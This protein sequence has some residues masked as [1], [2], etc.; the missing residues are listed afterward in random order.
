MFKN[1]LK[2]AV[3][4]TALMVAGCDIIVQSPTTVKAENDMTDLVVEINGDENDVS[5]ID[6]YNVEIGD[7]TW[8][9]I[10]AGTVTTAE[11]TTSSGSTIISIGSATATVLVSVLGNLTE[12][13]VDFSDIDDMLTDI[14]TGTV[15]TVVFDENTAANIL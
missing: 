10:Y 3:A 4:V 12:Q 1:V 8:S 13:E 9:A 7:I 15:N 11:E 14:A 2:T 6:L 5:G